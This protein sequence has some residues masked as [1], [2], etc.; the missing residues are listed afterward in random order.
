[1][2]NS[3]EAPQEAKNMISNSTPGKKIPV[4]TVPGMG[5]RGLIENAG[6]REFKYDIFVIL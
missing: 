6:W 2:E 3:V 5:E 1:M 4:E